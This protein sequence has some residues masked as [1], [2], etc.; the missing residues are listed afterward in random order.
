MIVAVIPA[1]GG[2][3]RIPRKNIRP[4]AGKPVIAYPIAAARDCRL[5]DRIIVTTDDEEIASVARAFGAETPFMRPAALA[6]DHMGTNEVT[7]HALEWLAANGTEATVACCIYPTAPLVTDA[8]LRSGYE[9]LT[10]SGKSFVFSASRFS[11]PIQRAIRITADGGV[12]AFFSQW[13]ERRSQDL[14]EAYHDAG[15]FYW[16]HAD[17]FRKGLPLFADHSA[18]LVLPRH[19]VQDIDTLEDWEHAERLYAALQMPHRPQARA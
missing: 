7:A 3:K 10:G 16:G 1:R 9:L 17:A 4:F 5:F 12:A 8:D 15:A 13:I 14:E 18:A 2:S 11:F 19:R 6:D